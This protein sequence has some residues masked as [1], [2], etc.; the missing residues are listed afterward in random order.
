MIDKG[1]LCNI[2]VELKRKAA[3]IT[4]DTYGNLQGTL[5]NVATSI[6]SSSKEVHL[7]VRQKL[8]HVVPFHE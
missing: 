2:P 4:W 7:K 6:M 8:K 3:F 1:K 5:L